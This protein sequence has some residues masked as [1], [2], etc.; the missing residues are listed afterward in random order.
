MNEYTYETIT[1]RD[2]SACLKRN[3]YVTIVLPKRRA[4]ITI[5]FIEYLNLLRGHNGNKVSV[6]KTAYI[7]IKYLA[8]L[9]RIIIFHRRL[10]QVFMFYFSRQPEYV[11]DASKGK[12]QTI[13]FFDV[14]QATFH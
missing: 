3:G 13:Q 4:S 11:H 2:L 10:F 14:S 9:F 6:A 7:F 5:R 1:S 8:L 12:R